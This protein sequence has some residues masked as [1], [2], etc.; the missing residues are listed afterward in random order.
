[1]RP[2]SPTIDMK[3]VIKQWGKNSLILLAI[4][5]ANT[6]AMTFQQ[7]I[8]LPFSVE[9]DSNPRLVE[10]NERSVQRFTLAPDYSLMATKGNEQFFANLR[11]RLEKS[12]NESVS[13]DRED[14]AVDLG[15]THNYE[16]GQF[17]I[18]ASLAEQS[19]RTSE[20]AETGQIDN[21]NTRQNRSFGINWSSA[22]SARYTLSA[23]AEI[24]KVTFDREAT[25]QNEFDNEAINAQLGY[26]VN[27]QLEA[28]TRL[29]FSRFDPSNNN[30][31]T[32]S[33]SL[34]VGATLTVSDTLTLS[35]NAG[36]N[37]TSGAERDSGWQ[38]M[39]S[40]D[41]TTERTRSNLDISRSRDPSSSGIV[42]ENNQFNV[43]FT[44][45][46]SERK[47]VGFDLSYR[48]NL[49][50]NDNETMT[51]S[52]NYTQQITPEW[53]FRLVASHRNRDDGSIDATSNSVTATIIYKLSDF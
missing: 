49:D 21:D 8:R 28:F 25:N 42:R 35:G 51:L 1:M 37:T 5:P 2:S 31:D 38:A 23:D 3:H 26:S 46:L 47:S 9:Y 14:P 39:F 32:R 6:F 43:G 44:Y 30:R 22:L 24:R 10:N 13:A 11:L 12:S 18:T 7:S 50:D 29:S 52:G 33:K 16:T 45:S 48:E 40:A 17:G 4:L 53:D 36:I 41:Y 15:W 20:F 34:V 27:E 19:T